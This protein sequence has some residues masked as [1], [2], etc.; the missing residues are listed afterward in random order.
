MTSTLVDEYRPLFY[1]LLFFPVDVS[2]I[3]ITYLTLIRLIDVSFFGIFD[4]VFPGWDTGPEPHT[5]SLWHI[6]HRRPKY[7]PRDHCWNCFRKRYNCQW[8]RRRVYTFQLHHFQH[9]TP[10]IVPMDHRPEATMP[11][12]LSTFYIAAGVERW[13]H[14]RARSLAATPTAA[15]THIYRFCVRC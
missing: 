8:S 14:R 7:P 15:V 13:C 5:L 3:V 9:Q 12:L 2:V 10:D 1:Q 11:L 4:R 6:L